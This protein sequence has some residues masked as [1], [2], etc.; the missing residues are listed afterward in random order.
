VGKVVVNSKF[1]YK[2]NTLGRLIK[3]VQIHFIVRC[4]LQV[5]HMKPE[6]FKVGLLN[7]IETGR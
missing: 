4:R 2:S 7:E 6:E 3:L 1:E 5:L